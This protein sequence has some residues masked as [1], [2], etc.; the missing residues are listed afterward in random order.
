MTY[1]DI[2]SAGGIVGQE[3]FAQQ[4]FYDYLVNDF[5]KDGMKV[6]EVGVCTGKSI[7]YL[8]NGLINKKIKLD[9]YG[10]D[11]FL[12]SPEHVNMIFKDQIA[13]NKEYLYHLCV[14]NLKKC[15]VYDYVSLMKIDSVNGA[16]KFQNEFFDVIIIDADHSYEGVKQDIDAWLPK[17]K[18][19]GII[20]GDDYNT[21]WSGVIQ[22]VDEKFGSKVQ[23]Y[24]TENMNPIFL[25]LSL[26][27]VRI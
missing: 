22:A 10:I 27:Y 17:L 9:L 26:W 23:L 12:G 19:G 3:N 24:N 4:P 11:H 15:N 5:L 21:G 25:P 16:S 1:K 20:A 18:P 14:D 8:A 2:I 13:D 7:T 6:V